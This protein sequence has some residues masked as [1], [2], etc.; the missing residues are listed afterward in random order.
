[1]SKKIT[2]LVK[3]FLLNV[4][5]ILFSTFLFQTC[6]DDNSP[7]E[8]K[9]QPS[10]AT[11]TIGSG[12]GTLKTDDF[13]LS[14]PIGAFPTDTKL[15]LKL[16]ENEDSGFDNIVSREFKIEGLPQ[17]FSQ[18][19]TIKIK[20]SGELTDSSYIAIGENGWV[21]SLAS[22]NES[23]RLL[24]VRDSSD[25][26][27]AVIPPIVDDV[28]LK[29]ELNST[30][31]VDDQSTTSVLAISGYSSY[32]SE[33]K[34]F[35]IDFPSSVPTEA[36][37]LASYLETA[38]S[39][40]K[41]LGFSYDRRTNWP[42]EVTVKK[43]ESTV[44]GLSTNSIWG[45]NYG[46]M[47]FN[48]DKM[49][50]AE[51]M[52][53][54]AGHEFFHLVQSLYDP[55]NRYSKAKFQSEN[56]WIHEA[57]SVWSEGLFSDKTD[58][59]SGAFSTSAGM[60]VYG[61]QDSEGDVA[62][63]YGYGMS[64]FMK[65]LSD[66]FGNGV[67]VKIYD[68]IYS[69]HNSFSAIDNVIPDP[70]FSFWD[71][72][73][74]EYLTYSL[75]K[76]EVFKPEWLTKE[77]AST[78]GSFVIRYDTD[79]IK[80]FSKKYND[81]SARIHSVR[82]VAA[83]LSAID[84]NSQ[85]VFET[86]G[87]ILGNIQLFKENKEE[88]VFLKQGQNSVTLDNFRSITDAGY[89]IIAVVINSR[90]IAPYKETS[91]GE[92]TIKVINKEVDPKPVITEIVDNVSL[93]YNTIRN[94][95]LPLSVAKIRGRNLRENSKVFI[96]GIESTLQYRMNNGDTTALFQMPEQPGNIS[97]KV[98][99]DAG[100]SNVYSYYCGI[101]FDY[102]ATAESVEIIWSFIVGDL[103]S[104][105]FLYSNPSDEKIVFPK[106]DFTWKGNILTVD[107]SKVPNVG[108]S[109]QYTFAA[110]GHKVENLKLDYT[111]SNESPNEIVHYL[112]ED[113]VVSQPNSGIKL[114]FRCYGAGPASKFLNGHTI[115]MTG[116]TDYYGDGR[117]DEFDSLRTFYPQLKSMY[118]NFSE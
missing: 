5:F 91:S 116:T 59:V 83:S 9:A 77:A 73:I 7:T 18:P 35:K 42:V 46:Y 3:I 88:S 104:Q 40:L 84:E 58:Y 95:T 90:L 86:E 23:Y 113:F 101:P 14:I 50:N 107:L 48:F 38:Y 32:I 2:L 74:Q 11:A 25:Y 105:R 109:V 51:E 94:F 49:G 17:S 31:K 24:K 111:R 70:T 6:S 75:Y 87:N 41:N 79:T 56:L 20:Y 89:V 60:V 82:T 99:S 47:E 22:E 45:D 54:T 26:L 36:I 114:G 52:K 67:F 92:L 37:D 30:N 78:G 98:V 13:E 29:T 69:G 63:Y 85:L 53:V 68:E 44:Y 72:F 28:L 57:L 4:L 110:T 55:R 34:H 118:L 12:G 115:S 62:N 80:T 19:L 112:G 96:N 97:V 117:I 106:S 1:M 103:G 108:G 100:E 39:E 61:A 76:G 81:L 27:V 102:L 16:V 66:N 43:L 21:S 8:P 64:A 15:T 71:E 33:Q 65:Y 10:L 93:Y